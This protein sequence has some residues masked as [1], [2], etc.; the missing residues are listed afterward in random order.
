MLRALCKML[1][2][3]ACY[4]CQFSN[5]S[6]II[7]IRKMH[8]TNSGAATLNF[9]RCSKASIFRRR[10]PKKILVNAIKFYSVGPEI[11]QYLQV[12]RDPEKFGNPCLNLHKIP[13]SLGLV[14]NT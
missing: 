11:P 3:L 7:K 8:V 5:N 9:K 2:V 14:E 1:F 4:K 10:F 13:Y 6:L 12:G